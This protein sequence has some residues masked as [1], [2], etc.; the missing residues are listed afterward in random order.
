MSFE[1]ENEEKR[2]RDERKKNIIKRSR[3]NCTDE[4]FYIGSPD[5]LDP[6]SGE[7]IY[8]PSQ[9]QLEDIE[10]KEKEARDQI[11]GISDVP[12]ESESQ[13]DSQAMSDDELQ[14][15][16]EIYQRL[17]A[18]AAADEAAKQA[19]IQALIQDMEVSEDDYNA[20]TGSYSGAYGKKPMSQSESDA[21][22]NIMNA[23]SSYSPSIEDIIAANQQ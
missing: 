15:A 21:V 7:P 22:A 6:Y 18:E 19:E 23:N 20:S 9:K 5:R 14:L 10:A 1:S 4:V 3:V 2:S 8:V 17:M 16:N 11:A 13:S 12:V